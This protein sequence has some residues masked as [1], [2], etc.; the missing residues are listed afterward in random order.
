MP[1]IDKRYFKKVILLGAPLLAGL[2]SEF[3]M[4]IADSVM[5]GRLGT[6]Y[7]AAIGIASMF[8]E[9]LWVIV[10]P[11]APGTQAIVARRFGRQ[12]KNSDKAGTVGL[13][14]IF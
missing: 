14:Y 7:L 13:L 6:D 1:K 11:M 2:V 9:L 3:L 5:V 4:I 12:N 8:G 10:W